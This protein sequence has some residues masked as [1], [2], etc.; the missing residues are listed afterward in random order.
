MLFG[1][2]SRYRQPVGREISPESRG[3][4]TAKKVCLATRS[5]NSGTA[6]RYSSLSAKYA[7]GYREH[8]VVW[9]RQHRLTVAFGGALRRAVVAGADSE[10]WLQRTRVQRV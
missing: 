9:K 7:M 6:T 1:L 3:S 8:L 2:L 5:A 4:D 10:A